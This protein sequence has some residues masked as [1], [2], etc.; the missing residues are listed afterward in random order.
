MSVDTVPVGF[1]VLPLTL[2]FVPGNVPKSAFAMSLVESPFTAVLGSVSPSLLALT[3]PHVTFPLANV[4]SAV[5][6]D[7][8][9]TFLDAGHVVVIHRTCVVLEHVHVP[10]SHLNLFL[11]HM[12]W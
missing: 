8:L 12:C 2:V 7:I 4:F 5:L 6:K 11:L 1:V 3:V 9:G 10:V